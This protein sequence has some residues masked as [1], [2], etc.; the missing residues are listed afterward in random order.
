MFLYVLFSCLCSEDRLCVCAV[1]TDCVYV[2][3]L[4]VQAELVSVFV[5]AFVFCYCFFC[6]CVCVCGG[7]GGVRVSRLKSFDDFLS[8]FRCLVFWLV[9]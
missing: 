8:E 9:S 6:L 5:C 3:C 7:G 4:C 2:L 1:K